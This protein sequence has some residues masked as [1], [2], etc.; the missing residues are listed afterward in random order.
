MHSI[1]DI[2]IH[3]INDGIT[4]ADAGGP[5]GLVPRALY[6]RYF[7]PDEQFMIPMTLHC[8]LVQVDG[9]NILIDTGLGDKLSAKALSN[10]GLTRPQGS[11]L[12]GLARLNLHPEDIDIV[13]NTHLHADHCSGNTQIDESGQVVPTFPNAEYV[14]QRREF[15]DAINPNERTAGTYDD[16]NWNALVERGQLHLLDG[17]KEI[18]PGVRGVITPGH[19]PGHMSVIIESA[20]QSALFACDMASFAVHFERLAWMTAYDVE[21]LVTLETKRKWQVWASQ[22]NALVVFPHDSK[23]PAGQ[24]VQDEDGHY[25]LSAVPFAYV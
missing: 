18:V 12:D 14:A 3:L 21:P 7:M 1:G 4:Q 16:I 19:T 13:I 24:L 6:S 20:G 17:D 15:T 2:T 9:R 5:F 23:R 22:N 11:L 10:W 8:L 25:R